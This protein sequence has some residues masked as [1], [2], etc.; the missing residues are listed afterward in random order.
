[1][2]SR[3][4]MIS[5]TSLYLCTPIVDNVS[6]FVDQ[7]LEGGVDIVQLREKQLPDQDILEKARTLQRLCRSR[8]VPFI[9][10]DRPDIALLAEA[11]GVHVGQDDIKVSDV[12]RLIG[13]GR[14]LGL[15][16]HS[17]T[18]LMEALTLDIDYVSVG[19]IEPTPTKPGRE[20]TGED[21]LN[22]ASKV[23]RLPF[24]V[25]GGVDPTKIRHLKEVGASR[26]VV[27][28][29]LVNAK[30]PKAAAQQLKVEIQRD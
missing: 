23:A 22:F 19:P 30:D 10:N 15:S 20:G 13:T 27:V 26:F 6:E 5:R 14:I 29:Y 2:V 17:R 16:T 1:M 21:F 7:T 12:R 4:E 25:T 8:S 11:D 24:F 3:T 18:E 9:V 28:R